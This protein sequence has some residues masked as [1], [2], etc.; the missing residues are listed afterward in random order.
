MEEEK[1]DERGGTVARG[2][3][4]GVPVRSGRRGAG[5]GAR[6]RAGP[7][8]GG[9]EIQFIRLADIIVMNLL[10]F[11]VLLVLLLPLARRPAVHR[12]PGSGHRREVAAGE[13]KCLSSLRRF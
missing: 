4:D 5:P 2:T 13:P 3:T 7:G 8:G 9:D 6:G 11:L 1:A 12:E 10:L